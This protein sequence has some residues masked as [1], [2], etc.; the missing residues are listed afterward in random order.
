MR[1]VVAFICALSVTFVLASR[2]S[3]AGPPCETDFDGV[4]CSSDNCLFVNNG[5][6]AGSCAAQEDGDMDGYGNACDTDVNNDGATG[7]DDVALT[8]AAAQA[9]SADPIFDFNCDGGI[10]LD[11]VSRVLSDSLAVAVP[12][13]SGLSC[14]GLIPCP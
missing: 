12:G 11:D 10:G 7:L 5:P 4:E 6:L 13:P 14:A 1:M 8:L 2:D 9:V 3:P